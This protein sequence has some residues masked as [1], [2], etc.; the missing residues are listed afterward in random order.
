MTI[1]K[2]GQSNW[3]PVAQTQAPAPQQPAQGAKDEKTSPE[4][5]ADAPSQPHGH[6]HGHE[7]ES[8]ADEESPLKQ[9]AI[10]I[11]VLVIFFLVL[12]LGLSDAP[13][14]L[15]RIFIFILAIIIGYMVI[16]NVTAALHTPLMSVTNAISGII[17]VGCMLELN[18]EGL[19]DA[20]S[21][22]GIIGVFFA[23][24][25]IFGGFIVTYKMLGMF[26]NH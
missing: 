17:V 15:N 4:K 8:G 26:K 11:I 9:T 16:W 6:G 13:V 19:F 18:T 7:E 5:K 12:G 14:L 22:F 10:T 24:I 25:N 1:V 2:E 21:I 3:P 23:S 20:E